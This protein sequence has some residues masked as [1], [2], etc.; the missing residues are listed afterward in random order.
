MILFGFE[1][2]FQSSIS[3]WL[4]YRHDYRDWDLGFHED[5][6]WEELF[7]TAPFP[8][9]HQKICHEEFWCLQFS[10]FTWDDCNNLCTNTSCDVLRVGLGEYSNLYSSPWIIHRWVDPSN[11]YSVSSYT[12]FRQFSPLSKGVFSS[13]TSCQWILIVFL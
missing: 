6:I 2:D 5:C 4:F 10:W 13:E 1:Q 8:Q 9:F 12:C 11:P 7:H 3:I